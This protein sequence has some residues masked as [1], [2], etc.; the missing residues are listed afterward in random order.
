[1]SDR[2]KAEDD[3]GCIWREQP[4]EELP[5]NLEHIVKRRTEEL[6]SSTRSE[7]LMSIGAALLLMG[8][9]AWR[10]QIVHERLLEFG[11]AGAIVWV[12]LSLYAFRGRIWR[13]NSARRDALAATGL[14]Y[15]RRELERRRDHLKNAWLWYGPLALAL[16]ILVAV[17]TGRANIAFQPLRNI[18]PLV[19]LLA[20]STVFGVWRRRLQARDLQREIDEI[21][22]LGRAEKGD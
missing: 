13:W 21:V 10:L 18:M 7:I 16:V 8:V 12:A 3:P 14:E 4:E 20:V 9:V 2:I 11:F 5:V 19:A 15:Y 22:P 6:S 17:L 1:M